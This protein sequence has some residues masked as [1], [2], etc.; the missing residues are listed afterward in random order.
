VPQAAAGPPG[1]SHS[2]ALEG[3]ALGIACAIAAGI[4]F[5]TLGIFSRLFYD[6]GGEEFTLLVLR[7]Y[8]ASAILIAVALWRRRPRPTRRDTRL[9]MVLGLATLAAS[10]CLFAGFAVAS[11]GLVTLLF[12]VYPL[13]TTVAASAF[14]GEELTRVK[15]ALLALGT[16]GIAFTVGIP[17]A[18]TIEGIAWGL[19]AGVCVSVF[20]LGSRYVMARSVDSF[21]FVALA[22]A[23]AAVALAPV[24]LIIGVDWPQGDARAHGVA[25][26]LL[27]TAVP[28]LLFYFAVS[29]I[30][31]GG[32]SRLATVEP[33]TAVLL[34]YL[35]LGDAMTA[36]QIAGGTL[37][38]AAVA[39]LASPP[40]ALRRRDAREPQPAGR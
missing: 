27:S 35:V 22:F 8:G 28:V 30:G 34:S 5:G 13:I 9:S 29:R 4:G 20:I 24:A 25:L 36:S 17:R 21:Q 18:A 14:L 11:P 23:S 32:A 37:V 31:A 10:V 16:L 2:A 3:P 7:F 40:G 12:Y 33:V 15:L 39:L 1:R 26:V 19:G 6:A 38:V